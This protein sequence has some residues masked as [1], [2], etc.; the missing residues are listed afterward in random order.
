MDSEG[1]DLLTFKSIFEKGNLFASGCAVDYASSLIV[2]KPPNGANGSAEGSEVLCGKQSLA[3]KIPL[4]MRIPSHKI[5]NQAD[6]RPWH[7]QERLPSSGA[8]RLLVFAGDI[9]DPVQF[10][11]YESLGKALASPGGLIQKYKLPEA[12]NG[13]ETLVEIITI[14]SSPRV[15]VELP[16]I[17]EIFHPFSAEYGWDYEKIFVDDQSYHEGHGK[18]YENYGI[19]P[20]SGALVIVR[21]DQYVSWI[22]DLNDVSDIERFFSRVIKVQTAI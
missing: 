19:D 4:G 5:L 18:A 13:L 7:L 20:R 1:V 6:A 3:S 22:G 16:Y 10:A 8:W 14:H 9:L 15:K 12:L 21:P 2:A 11:R 17:P